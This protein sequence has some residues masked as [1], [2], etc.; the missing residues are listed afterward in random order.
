MRDH[1]CNQGNISNMAN[2]LWYV[3]NTVLI[4]S[5]AWIIPNYPTLTQY[6]L[7]GVNYFCPLTPFKIY[8]YF[9]QI[10]VSFLVVKKLSKILPRKR[11]YVRE[12]MDLPPHCWGFGAV[13]TYWYMGESTSANRWRSPCHG[14]IFRRVLAILSQVTGVG[15]S[16]SSFGISILFGH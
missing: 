11:S 13:A 1:I 15:R 14:C 12:R 8:G 16:L 6:V 5:M 2:I 9:C 4:L 3:F 10:F 7:I